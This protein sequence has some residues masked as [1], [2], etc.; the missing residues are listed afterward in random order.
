MNIINDTQEHSVKFLLQEFSQIDSER[1]RLRSEAVQRLNF[2]LTLTSA[3]LGGLVLFGNSANTS[4]NEFLA[5]AALIA[6]SIIG[7][8]TYDFIVG[9]DINSDRLLRAG[10]RIRRY[11]ADNDPAIQKYLMWQIHDEPSKYITHNDSAVRR[12]IE[13]IL[14]FL[15][16]FAVGLLVNIISQQSFLTIVIIGVVTFIVFLS[17]LEFYASRRFHRAVIDAEAEML[18]PKAQSQTEG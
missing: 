16:S 3:V 10:G 18:H 15:V 5:L 9:R 4:N 1:L 6:L 17:G 13:S 8:Q 11:F 12:T 2:F 14:A 7:W